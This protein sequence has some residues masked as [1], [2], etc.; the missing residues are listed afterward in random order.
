[1][2]VGDLLVAKE[3]KRRNHDENEAA[4]SAA[5]ASL[6]EAQKLA[7]VFNREVHGRLRAMPDIADGAG[8]GSVD[9]RV[10]RIVFVRLSMYR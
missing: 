1:M 9:R 8:G 6:E 2:F 3:F 4:A 7:V 10:W 5:A